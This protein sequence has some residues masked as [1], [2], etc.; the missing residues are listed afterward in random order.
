M[1]F[2]LQPFFLVEHTHTGP[3][4]NFAKVYPPIKISC[5]PI[6]DLT[7][8]YLYSRLIFMSSIPRHTT[9]RLS[10]CYSYE[11]L[12]WLETSRVPRQ[13]ITLRMMTGYEN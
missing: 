11:P 1:S 13:N 9:R 5:F 4:L 7:N 2:A 3:G 8:S 12:A 10:R 6:C